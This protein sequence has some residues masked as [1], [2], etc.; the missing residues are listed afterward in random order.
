MPHRYLL[1]DD[2]PLGEQT[3]E[4]LDSTMIGAAKSFLTGRKLLSIE[5]PYGFG[6][7]AIPLQDCMGDGGVITS[8]ILPIHLI[9]TTFYLARRDLAAYERDGLFLD[10]RAVAC[11]ALELAQKE[12]AL[13]FQGP[14]GNN[15]LMTMEG[16]GSARL[17]SWNTIGKAA[18]D[19]IQAITSLDQSG[20]S[21]PYAMALT[22]ARYNLLLRRYPQGGT[23]YDHIRGFITGGVFK[24]PILDS[25]GI[26]L[27]TGQFNSL[28]IGQDMQIGFIGPSGENL[29]FT[30]SESLVLAV[31]EPCSICSLTEK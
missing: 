29:E 8:G 1:R 9:Q 5:G 12:D 24:A 30:I 25:G 17:S 22:P 28:V 16:T 15:G 7:K 26:I 18:D 11:A 27:A 3:W 4:L 21:G 31:R 10:L 2:A 19:V 13:I 23:E 20:F 6:L 14:S